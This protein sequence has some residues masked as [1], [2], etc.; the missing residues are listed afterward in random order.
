MQYTVGYRGYVIVRDKERAPFNV[1]YRNEDGTPGRLASPIQFW[2][3]ADAR[4]EVDYHL[5]R[6]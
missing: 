4:R 2:S 6:I 3:F 5:P 1:R